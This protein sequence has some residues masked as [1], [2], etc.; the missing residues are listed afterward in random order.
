MA[1]SWGWLS[2]SLEEEILKREPAGSWASLP[3]GQ[4]MAVTSV[5]PGGACRGLINIFK[6]CLT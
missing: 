6:A 3:E 4:P 5:T 2:G 1:R